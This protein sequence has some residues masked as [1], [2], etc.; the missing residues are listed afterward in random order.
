MTWDE[1]CRSGATVRQEVGCSG[2]DAVAGPPTPS[3]GQMCL[4]G[5]LMATVPPR[6]SLQEPWGPQP[7][8]LLGT[9]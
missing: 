1:W 2:K 7:H 3:G 5:S 6:A 4:W 8:Y 9:L